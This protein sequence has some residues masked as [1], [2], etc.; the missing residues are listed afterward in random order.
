MANIA[1][2]FPNWCAG[3]TVATPSID[4]AGSWES[5][6][7]AANVL[8]RYLSKVARSV[9]ATTASTKL[10]V[11]LGVPR[12]VRVAGVVNANLS[13]TAQIRARG[14]SDSGYSTEVASTD[15]VD[16]WPDAY[17]WGA[18]PWGY[19]DLFSPKLSAEEVAGYPF[20]WYYAWSTDQIA[21]Y[22]ELEF[23][24]ASNADGYVEVG[25]VVL[26]PVWQA[27]INPLP[28]ATTGWRTGTRA[29]QGRTGT[30][31]FDVQVPWRFGRYTF[32]HLPEAEVMAAPFDMGR[33]QNLDGEIF[34]I[35]DPDDTV[36]AV[37]RGFLANLR[38][39]PTMQ[40]PA[41]PERMGVVVEIEEAR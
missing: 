7:P 30:K 31:F 25:R 11:D 21:R 36:H 6:L 23:S 15:W 18:R 12:N 33:R 14:Y 39:L 32:E 20:G 38:E 4:A 34:L 37:R 19:P 29:V 35:H 17:A 2:G 5:S 3:S 8:D 41:T 40:Y 26:A 10:R 27:S 1:F 28:G 24:D 9:D 22:W 16:A 13:A